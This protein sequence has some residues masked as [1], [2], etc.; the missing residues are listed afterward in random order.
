VAQPAPDPDHV[1]QAWELF[2]ENR[3]LREIAEILRS[4]GIQVSY[5]GVRGWIKKA[6]TAEA[7]MVA[8]SPSEKLEKHEL[9]RDRY[10]AFLDRIIRDGIDRMSPAGGGTYE[11]VA[12]VVL[13]AGMEQAKVLGIYAPIRAVLEGNVSVPAPDSQ[14]AAIVAAMEE[15][16]RRQATAEGR[17]LLSGDEES[18]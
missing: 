1:A 15:R 11:A 2:C 14:T 17:A 5:E 9:L 13:R 10:L 18:P 16:A 3:T 6:R 7:F 4:R 8:E 12:P